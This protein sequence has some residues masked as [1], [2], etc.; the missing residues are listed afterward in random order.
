MESG[1]FS[2]PDD[3]TLM[4]QRVPDVKVQEGKFPGWPFFLD[5]FKESVEEDLYPLHHGPLSC[6]DWDV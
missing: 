1:V 2:L 6:R 4:T 5:D 3:S